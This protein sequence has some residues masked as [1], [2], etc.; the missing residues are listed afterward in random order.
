MDRVRHSSRQASQRWQAMSP[1]CFPKANL[2][3][4]VDIFELPI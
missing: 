2:I 3:D 4:S 1:N